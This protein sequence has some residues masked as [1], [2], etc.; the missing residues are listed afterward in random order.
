MATPT[1]AEPAALARPK[2]PV[3]SPG[4]SMEL[5]FEVQQFLYR[6]ARLLDEERYEEWLGLMTEDIHYWMPGIQARHRRD[7]APRLDPRRMAFFDDDLL[8]MRRR[9]TRFLTP[10]AWAEDPPTRACHAISNVEVEPAGA[11]NEFIVHSTFINTRGRGE[12]EEYM[13]SG[14]RKDRLR[15]VE[16]GTLRLAAREIVIT[17]TVLLAKNLNVFL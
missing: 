2:P 13:L 12:A 6:E 14:R 7:P 1:P 3:A 17:Q 4:A 11:P 5:V 16:D 8:N 15:R 10:T 9:V